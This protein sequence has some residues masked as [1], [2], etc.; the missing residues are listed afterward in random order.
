MK[1]KP[2]G[3]NNM[4]AIILSG[5][6][7]NFKL[8]KKDR[9]A[10]KNKAN[11]SVIFSLDIYSFNFGANWTPEVTLIINAPYSRYVRK[12]CLDFSGGPMAD[13]IALNLYGGRSPY[14]PLD[15]KD[16]G[17]FFTKEKMEKTKWPEPAKEKKKRIKQRYKGAR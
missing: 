5:G 8:T 12:N 17:P 10:E 9:G 1:S 11:L 16:N 15:D 7:N 3:L 13:Q 14:K 2:E 6:F 4:D